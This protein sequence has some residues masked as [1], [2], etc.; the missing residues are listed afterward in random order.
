MFIRGMTLV[1]CLSLLGGGAAYAQSGAQAGSM[2]I[3][4]VGTGGPELTPTRSGEATLVQA[5][6]ESLLFDA[7]RGVLQGLYEC[8]VR[9]QTVTRIFLTH[10][11]SDHI[12]GL[13]G[14][15]MTP[16]FLLGRKEHLQVW[17]PPG[18]K[19]M[20]DGMRQMYA[21]DLEHRVNNV[22]RLEYLDIDVHEVKPGPVYT[23]GGVTVT[24]VSVEH[25]D[26]NPAW[27]YRVEANGRAVVL[28]GDATYSD[29]LLNAARGADVVISNVAAGTAELERSGKIDP[30]LDK[31]MRPEQAAKIFAEDKP[32]LAVYSHIVKKGLPGEKGDETLIQ[33]TRAAGYQGALEVGQDRME[34]VVGQTIRVVPP[35]SL[36]GLEDFDG[37]GS[38]FTQQK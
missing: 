26:G 32:R 1:V 10:L 31:L 16:W 17:G 14:L 3:Y 25:R 22:A 30:I 11:H 4:L 13:P 9:P 24:A 38:V 33:R 18:T 2:N 21:H 27:G 34:I 12:E 19:A 6:G 7:G 36:D 23:D 29:G 28:T 20:V 37:P 8:R 35:R 5:N 15:W